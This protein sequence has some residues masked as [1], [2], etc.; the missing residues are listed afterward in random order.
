MRLHLK[1]RNRIDAWAARFIAAVAALIAFEWF[2]RI[3]PTDELVLQVLI[4]L[5]LGA[6]GLYGYAKH[7]D[8]K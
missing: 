2:F 5:V 8:D 1:F 4:A 6:V 3:A 7:L